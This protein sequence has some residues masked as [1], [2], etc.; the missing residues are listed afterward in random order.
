[1]NPD[2]YNFHTLV[3]SSCASSTHQ[4]KALSLPQGLDHNPRST[5]F[6][7]SWNAGECRWPSGRCRFRHACEA[8][9]GDHRSTSAHTGL[10]RR[11]STPG[12]P[13]HR[14]ARDD[15]AKA[16]SPQFVNSVNNLNS[17]HS[18]QLRFSSSSSGCALSSCSYSSSSRPYGSGSSMVRTDT[19]VHRDPSEFAVPTIAH[20]AS[21]EVPCQAGIPQST[22][23]LPQR[24]LTLDPS[25]SLDSSFSPLHPPGTVSPINV[26]KLE[27]ELRHFPDRAKAEY[28][29]AGL[30]YGFH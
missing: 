19:P 24:P 11:L 29:I 8:F 17:L 27:F 28:V 15:G 26:D 7:H 25:P 30:C 18:R 2:L 16:S 10:P 6:C 1:M 14:G 9:S 12:H 21:I 23:S 20:Q 3:P 22:R 4:P 5:Q 13:H